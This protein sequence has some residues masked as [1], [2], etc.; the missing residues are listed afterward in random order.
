[1]ILEMHYYTHAHYGMPML[2][3]QCSR[4]GGKHMMRFHGIDKCMIKNERAVEFLS[5]LCSHSNY[6]GVQKKCITQACF[7]KGKGVT[8]RCEKFRIQESQ[9]VCSLHFAF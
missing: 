5:C 1:M 3:L 4:D 7:Y 8:F 9:I 2:I 6:L